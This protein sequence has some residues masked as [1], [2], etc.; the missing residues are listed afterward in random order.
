MQ[1]RIVD[2]LAY[3]VLGNGTIWVGDKFVTFYY[4]SNCYSNIG[5]AIRLAD[6]YN[7]CCDYTSDVSKVASTIFTSGNN[8]YMSVG[9]QS[10]VCGTK[11]CK[12]TYTVQY[13]DYWWNG[14]STLFH[15]NVSNISTEIYAIGNCMPTYHNCI[16][17]ENYYPCDDGICDY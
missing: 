14:L 10:N 8:S 7:I 1:L 15:T 2:Y 13:L 9:V 16:D 11:C 5:C 17:Q 4:P 6:D 12:K 3:S